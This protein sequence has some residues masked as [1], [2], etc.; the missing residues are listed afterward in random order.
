GAGGGGGDPGLAR[1]ELPPIRV[2]QVMAERD[3]MIGLEPVK[4]QIRQIA[5]SVEAAE[6]RR[7]AG[8]QT[9][10]PMQHFVFLGPPGTGKTSVAR[11]IAKIYYAFELLP[12]P[13]VVEAL[14]ADLS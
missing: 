12:S 11:I 4:E 10:K 9:D 1:A 7:D 2:A 6:R 14:R 8:Y 5:A 13:H 3:A